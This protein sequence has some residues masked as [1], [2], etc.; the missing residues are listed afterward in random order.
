MNWTG[1]RCTNSLEL[2]VPFNQQ[3]AGYYRFIEACFVC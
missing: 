1:G 2:P 3:V